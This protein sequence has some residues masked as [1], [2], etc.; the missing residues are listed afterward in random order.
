MKFG[1]RARESP[2]FFRV[3]FTNGCINQPVLKRNATSE[4]DSDAFLGSIHMDPSVEI[5]REQKKM[6]RSK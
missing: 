4:Y 6:L 5:E 1:F 2:Y 3:E